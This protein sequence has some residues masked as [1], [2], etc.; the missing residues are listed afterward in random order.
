[1][2]DKTTLRKLMEERVRSLD[3]LKAAFLLSEFKDYETNT[4]R[5]KDLDREIKAESDPDIRKKI[6]S[7]RH[8]LVTEKASIFSHIMRHLGDQPKEK[9]ALDSFLSG[10]DE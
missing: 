9:S 2:A 3:P 7:E 6:A 8:Q 1:M 5:I 10:D 4:R